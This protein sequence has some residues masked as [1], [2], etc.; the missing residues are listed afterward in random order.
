[1]RSTWRCILLHISKISIL[2]ISGQIF[3]GEEY[4]TVGLPDELE[5]IDRPNCTTLAFNFATVL[6]KERSE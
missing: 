4:K 6:D 2:L 5:F 1:M 3:E